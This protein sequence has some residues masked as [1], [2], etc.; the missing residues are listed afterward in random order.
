M[1]AARIPAITNPAR[2]GGRKDSASVTKIFS[3]S[4]ALR[5]AVGKISLPTIPIN[6]AT[7]REIKTHTMAILLD[8]FSSRSLRIAMKRSST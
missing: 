3:A 1:V 8:I 7:V 2:I 6:T 5:C 4:V